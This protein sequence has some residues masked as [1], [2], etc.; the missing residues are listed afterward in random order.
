MAPFIIVFAFGYLAGWFSA[1]PLRPEEGW[2]F[3]HEFSFSDII[4]LLNAVIITFLFTTYLQKIAADERTEKTTL[5]QLCEASITCLFDLHV[6]YRTHVL[7]LTDQPAVRPQLPAAGVSPIA[8]TQALVLAP[9]PPNVKTKKVELSQKIYEIQRHITDRE[10]ELDTSNLESIY[11]RYEAVIAS[12]DALK[13]E[14]SEKDKQYEQVYFEEL[15]FNIRKL[16]LNINS[17]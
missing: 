12:D 8:S 7:N 11:D 2:T 14:F 3:K 6:A 10:Y 15:T 5:M 16:A 17:N 9:L 1:I 13:G 4:A